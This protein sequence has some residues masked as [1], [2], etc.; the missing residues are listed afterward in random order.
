[1]YGTNNSRW[2]HTDIQNRR[3]GKNNN[4]DD[5]KITMKI[6]QVELECGNFGGICIC[7][8]SNSSD[9]IKKTIIIVLSRKSFHDSNDWMDT[10]NMRVNNNRTWKPPSRA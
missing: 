3:A 10:N 1:M 7:Y 9:L 2:T 4:N 6:I 8:I 5:N